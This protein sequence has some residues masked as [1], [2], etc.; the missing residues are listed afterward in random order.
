VADQS[1]TMY[2]DGLHRLEVYRLRRPAIADDPQFFRMVLAAD[3]GAP[4]ARDFPDYVDGEWTFSFNPGPFAWYSDE[5]YQLDLPAAL[6]LLYRLADVAPGFARQLDGQAVLT[7]HNY[8]PHTEDDGQ[9]GTVPRN[10]RMAS[11]ASE[12]YFPAVRCRLTKGS[13]SEEFWV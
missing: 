13:S 3:R 8:Y 1:H 5:H 12:R 9:G 6:R 7:V 11:G 2:L 10:V 4:I